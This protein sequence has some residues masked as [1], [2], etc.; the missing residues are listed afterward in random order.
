MLT[1]DYRERQRDAFIYGQPGLHESS[2][3][4]GAILAK[5]TDRCYLVI[6]GLEVCHT[7]DVVAWDFLTALAAA[8][9]A[10]SVPI[11]ILIT[12]RDAKSI[13]SW[14]KSNKTD[15]TV[16]TLYLG[17]GETGSASD[18][19]LFVRSEV[20][21]CIKNGLLLD[22]DVDEELQ[23]LICW[24][25]VARARGLFEWCRDQLD[26]LC[27]FSFRSEVEAELNRLPDLMQEA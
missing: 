7:E 3:L 13:H 21:R 22:G 25:L 19:E 18:L 9:R 17:A 15:Q 24:A 16:H 5:R 6:D 20:Q 11:K 12:S 4:L 26:H 1:D 23:N 14:M 10:A 8:V 2:K 27:T